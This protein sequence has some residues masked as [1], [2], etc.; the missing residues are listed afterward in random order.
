MASTY[1]MSSVNGFVSSKRRLHRPPNS[2]A[3]PKLRQTDFTCPRW[4]KPL[5][6]GGKRVATGRSKRSVATSSATIS[7]MKSLRAAGG[8]VSE[9]TG[10]FLRRCGCG[11]YRCG[12]KPSVPLRNLELRHAE[13]DDRDVNQARPAWLSTG[14][15]R[16][17]IGGALTVMKSD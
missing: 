14:G 1:L 10:S 4:G 8:A 15:A 7:L 9:G 5:G 11:G 6:S 2:R 17:D 13:H 12:W 3:M 16:S